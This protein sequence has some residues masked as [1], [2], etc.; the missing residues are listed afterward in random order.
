MNK[1]VL[2][3]GSTGMLGQAFV[4]EAIEDPRIESIL[5]INRRSA[6]I[7]HD[8]VKEILH[9]DFHDFSSIH[10]ELQPFDACCFC[11]GT[12]AVGKNEQTYHH[13]TFGIIQ[14]LIEQLSVKTTEMTFLYISG[15][16]TDSTEKGRAMW[17]RVKGKTENF[18]IDT[19]KEA[20]MF[21]PGYI[22]PM[23]GVKSATNWYRWIYA[24]IG[25]TYPLLRRL[26]PR[27]VMTTIDLAKSQINA[28]CVGYHRKI[29][30]TS[31]IHE[32]A[33]S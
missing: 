26:F 31:D 17:A 11:L 5:L 15:A 19:F 28:I 10:D 25:F 23:K 30:E 4:L 6:G 16:G 29:L 20:Y 32:L 7:T 12:S 22:Q 24:A 14:A 18:L 27:S 8:K 33:G 2:V 13:I 3:F 1:K 9:D 21:R